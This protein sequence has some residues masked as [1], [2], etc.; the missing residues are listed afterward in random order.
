MYFLVRQSPDFRPSDGTEI[1]HGADSGTKLSFQHK[2][3][4][5]KWSFSTNASI[6]NI[7]FKKIALQIRLEKRVQRLKLSKYNVQ[8]ASDIK[9]RI[10]QFSN[11]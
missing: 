1:Y 10:L 11:F 5:V 4:L 7:P 2:K 3:E 9:K 8:P 6:Q